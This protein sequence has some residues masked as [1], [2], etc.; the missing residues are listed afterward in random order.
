MDDYAEDLPRGE[1]IRATV[2]SAK[3]NKIY[4]PK[5]LLLP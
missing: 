5:F 3:I 1:L 4:I 2:D